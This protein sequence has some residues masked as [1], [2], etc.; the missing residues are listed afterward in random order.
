MARTWITKVNNVD[1][2][3]AAHVNDLQT[4]KLDKDELPY[5]RPEDYGAVGDGVHDDTAAI[6]STIAAGDGGTILLANQKIY[7]YAT[8]IVLTKPTIIKG[9][10]KGSSYLRYTPLAGDAITIDIPMTYGTYSFGGSLRD[11]SLLGSGQT[12]TTHP[13]AVGSGNGIVINSNIRGFYANVLARGFGNDGW[14]METT[15]GLSNADG[16]V[17]L[18]CDGHKNGRH[19][20]YIGPD[21]GDSNIIQI[22]GGSAYENILDGYFLKCLWPFIQLPD[23]SYN[24]RWG[25]NFDVAASAT[26]KVFGENNGSGTV[27]FSASSGYNSIELHANAELVVDDGNHNS[28]HDNT[29]GLPG[30]SNLRVGSIIPTADDPIRVRNKRDSQV[31]IRLLPGLNVE[32]GCAYTL[33]NKAGNVVWAIMKGANDSFWIYDYNWVPAV[34]RILL[35]QPIGPDSSTHINSAGGGGIYFNQMPDTGVGNVYFESGGPI[36]VLLASI[37]NPTGDI[38]T[39]GVYKVAGTQVIGPQGAAVADA[40]GAGDVVAQL[41]ALLA[42]CRAHGII[43]I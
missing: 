2:V 7:N 8:P 28:Y 43:D 20:F 4:Y 15:G 14:H 36:P 38:D 9:G 27:Y 34:P 21:A 22:I 25:F 32:E 19:G 16:T 3:D 1:T 23:G 13:A 12:P 18:N 41:N 39:I 40:T 10:G 11:F 24:G 35:E 17:F 31:E 42:R 29:F 5:V 33:G 26:G 6:A 37:N 30:W